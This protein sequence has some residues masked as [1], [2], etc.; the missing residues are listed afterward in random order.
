MQYL[1]TQTRRTLLRPSRRSL[2]IQC[3]AYVCLSLEFFL[4]QVQRIRMYKQFFDVHRDSFENVCHEPPEED[5]ASTSVSDSE[6]V[7][8]I[9]DEIEQVCQCQ[10]LTH[11]FISHNLTSPHTASICLPSL[12]VR[13]YYE[14]C[15]LR[16]HSGSQ[17]ILMRQTIAW[18]KM[19]ASSETCRLNA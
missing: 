17:V 8:I 12:T 10:Q 1:G 14:S 5:C 3:D 15:T 6:D 2:G 18:R 16:T 19:R 13:Y 9:E 4:C 7:E 11:T